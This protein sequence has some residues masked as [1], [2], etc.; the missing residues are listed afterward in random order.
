M[1]VDARAVLVSPR[2]KGFHLVGDVALAFGGLAIGVGG[3]PFGFLLAIFGILMLVFSQV[4]ILHRWQVNRY[5]GPLLGRRVTILADEVGLHYASDLATTNI[6][7]S[8]L[9]AVRSNEETVVFLRERALVSYVPAS[10]FG[11]SG[12]QIEFVRF[13]RAHIKGAA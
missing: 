3:Y 4:D 5:Y 6:P 10:A 7:W 8:T 13:A 2:L 11:S 12:E 9:T 1:S